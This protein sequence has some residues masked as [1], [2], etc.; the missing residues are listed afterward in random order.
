[1]DTFGRISVN[2]PI[3]G[4]G[5]CAVAVTYQPDLKTFR[6]LLDSILPQ[7][8]KVV[9]VDNHS[10]DEKLLVLERWHDDEEF[11]LIPQSNNVGIAAAHNIG[12][13]WA[14]VHGF[15]YVLLLDQDSLPEPD[16]VSQL[17]AASEGLK[18]DGVLV[19]AV[20]PQFIDV[21]LK[22]PLPFV[23][24]EGWRW[25]KDFAE[26]KKIVK[27][28]FLISSGALIPI[29]A[30]RRIGMMD[31][32]LFIDFV[33]IE[34]GLRAKADGYGCF[35]VCAAIMA[36]SLGDDPIEFWGQRYPNH[37]PLRHYYIL[38]NALLLYRRPY[39]AW[40]WKL[41]HVLK[42]MKIMILFSLVP[43]DRAQQF[44]MMC[45]G[46]WHGLLGKKGGLQMIREGRGSMNE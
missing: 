38:R 12:I 40:R 22:R 34:W 7:V 30:I 2:D 46:L 4:S 33:D 11:E 27:A 25:V 5:V 20:G 17:C 37:S 13:D 36:H 26:G 32:S 35:G 6:L 31:A 1:M 29:D 44:K 15:Q 39:I 28:D 19:G 14:A 8:G 16:M 10:S 24:F 18:S 41:V 3:L 9:V 23:R 21:R 43:K 45:K 42:L